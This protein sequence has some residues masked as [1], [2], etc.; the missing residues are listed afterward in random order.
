MAHMLQR[1]AKVR[2]ANRDG[3]TALH[4]A[5]FRNALPCMEILLR[6]GADRDAKDSNGYQVRCTFM[7]ATPLAT[8]QLMRNCAW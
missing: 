4:W 2:A 3:A 6:A 5:V 7:K 1:G 8:L